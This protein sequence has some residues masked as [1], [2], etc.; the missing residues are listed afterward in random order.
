MM[1]VVN[2]PEDQVALRVQVA[3]GYW[4]NTET[5]TRHKA[6]QTQTPQ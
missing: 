2:D 4:T 3:R 5:R 6:E 1:N